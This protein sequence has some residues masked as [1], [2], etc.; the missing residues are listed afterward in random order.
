[1]IISPIKLGADIVVYSMTKFI[2]GK[3]D[4]IAGAICGTEEFIN[5]LI[6]GS[7]TSDNVEIDGLIY[8][9][10]AT[11]TGKYNL[12]TEA[13]E[14]WG[15]ALPPAPVVSVVS[16]GELPPGRYF[17]CYTILAGRG[18]AGGNGDICT[19][20]FEGES[21]GIV[22]ANYLSSYLCWITDANGKDFYLA[23]VQS[24][25]ITSRYYGT[26]LQSLFVVSPP[27]MTVIA[28]AFGRIWGIK[29][30]FLYYSEPGAY[31]WFKDA[32]CFSFPYD[33]SLYF[34]Y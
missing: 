3:N 17:L 34:C 28:Y 32:N 7:F 31:E 27:K 26:P 29:G 10:S 18:V 9:S 8:M 1:M 33:R 4:C 16:D 22:L 5:S 24:D 14:D 23:D 2:N 21:K 11:W 12:I 15:V 25:K 13:I 20:E 30:R 6:I 19:I